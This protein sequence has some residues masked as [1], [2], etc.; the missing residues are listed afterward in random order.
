MNIL[1]GMSTR[2]QLLACFIFHLLTGK[3]FF[4]LKPVMEMLI[5][6]LEEKVQLYDL[7]G[8]LCARSFNNNTAFYRQRN[9]FVIEI[10]MGV[11]QQ[12]FRSGS[13]IVRPLKCH[14]RRSETS[15]DFKLVTHSVQQTFK[16]VVFGGVEG[17]M[18]FCE[19]LVSCSK[20][21]SHY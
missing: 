9:Y 20:G 18:H 6:D 12:S 14:N 3:L 21:I 2:I 17:Y 7:F 8:P 10:L 19:N 11:Q 5:P 4:C 1:S 13:C 16:S 15:S